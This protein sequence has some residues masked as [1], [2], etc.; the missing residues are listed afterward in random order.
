MATTAALI[1][2]FC[3]NPHTGFNSAPF[4]RHAI[5]AAVCARE[6]AVALHLN[7]EYAYTTGLLHDIGRL[8]LVTQIQRNYEATMAYRA[9]HDC[10]LLDAER[11]VLG[12]DHALVSLVLARHWKFPEPMQQAG[13][14][15]HA[16]LLEDMPP[17]SL[18]AL[19]ADVIAH[20]LDLSLDPDDLVPTIPAGLWQQLGLGEKALHKVFER[21]EHQFE[22]ASLILSA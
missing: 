19:A 8:V 14:C 6:L 3:A 18:V 11:A 21:A 2:T 9:Q 16:P 12:V 13:A 5:A 10:R 4:W 20:A 22:A 17:L 15:H 7:P 1:S